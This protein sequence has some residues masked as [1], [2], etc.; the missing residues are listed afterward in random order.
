MDRC[1]YFLAPV[2]SRRGYRR[3]HFDSSCPAYPNSSADPLYP[4]CVHQPFRLAKVPWA[5]KRGDPN[6]PQRALSAAAAAEQRVVVVKTNA[7]EAKT[8]IVG[9]E[10]WDPLGVTESFGSVNDQTVAF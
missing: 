3:D 8:R 6:L 10:T 2:R 7:R 1:C 5:A 4:H 9:F